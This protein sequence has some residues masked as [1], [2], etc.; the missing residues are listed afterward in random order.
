VFAVL[1]DA[2][3]GATV[4]YVREMLL[5]YGCDYAQSTELI[6]LM[7]RIKLI[8]QIGKNLLLPGVSAKKFEAKKK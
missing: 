6:D 8:R 2:G 4:D 3:G 7:V 5:D 1:D